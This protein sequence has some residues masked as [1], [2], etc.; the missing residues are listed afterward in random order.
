MYYPTCWVAFDPGAFGVSPWRAPRTM[1][2]VGGA[3]W[4]IPIWGHA[5]FQLIHYGPAHLF[6]KGS[7]VIRLVPLFYKI[8]YPPP[9]P[10]PS[11]NQKKAHRIISN[12]IYYIDNIYAQ[13][14]R[15]YITI[16]HK[17]I[18]R[19]GLAARSRITYQLVDAASKQNC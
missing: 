14:Q 9:P 4:T 18:R 3:S 7:R 2:V 19:Q 6:V 15:T 8:G 13:L 17:G 5:P 1:F 11:T 12:Y 10:P 16:E